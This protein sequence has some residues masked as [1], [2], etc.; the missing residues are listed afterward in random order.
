MNIKSYKKQKERRMY[1][2]QKLI[3][4]FGG[5]CEVCGYNKNAAALAFH[6]KNP[7]TKSFMLGCHEIGCRTWDAIVEEANKCQLLCQNCH[8]ELHYPYQKL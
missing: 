5:G 2:K 6:H 1:R 8:H 7:K 4:M 3:E